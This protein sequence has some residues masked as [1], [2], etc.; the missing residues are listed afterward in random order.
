M[1]YIDSVSAHTTNFLG[2]IV[3]KTLERNA[4]A[5][6]CFQIVNPLFSIIFHP[7]SIGLTPNSF[8]ATAFL[9]FAFMEWTHLGR[10][11]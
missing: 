6:E 9:P 1:Q 11:L 4:K 7:T 2:G 8:L 5:L 3:F 10:G